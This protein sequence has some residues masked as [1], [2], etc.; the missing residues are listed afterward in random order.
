MSKFK[1]NIDQLLPLPKRYV[2]SSTTPNTEQSL[3]NKRSKT[4]QDPS[5]F[6]PREEKIVSFLFLPHQNFLSTKKICLPYTWVIVFPSHYFILSILFSLYPLH[7]YIL[8]LF[9]SFFSVQDNIVWSAH[10][11]KASTKRSK[12]Q[13]SC[14]E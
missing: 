10:I 7:V 13:D 3:T 11:N 1:Q 5:Y 8:L 4:F 12:S 6:I 9:F 14:C 2:I